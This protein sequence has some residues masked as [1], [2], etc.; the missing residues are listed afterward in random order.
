MRCLQ[1]EKAERASGSSNARTA[2]GTNGR[3]ARCP[4]RRAAAARS[5]IKSFSPN[6][7]R[8]RLKR[9]GFETKTAQRK[10]EGAVLSGTAPSPMLFFGLSPACVMSAGQSRMTAALTTRP[11]P[12][13]QEAVTQTMRPRSR[14]ALAALLFISLAMA[15]MPFS[16]QV[17]GLALR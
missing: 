17:L 3:N 16:S 11:T 13:A 12:V 4:G 14:I 15:S 8:F 6:R 7:L 5:A 10:S 1:N 2:A 9:G